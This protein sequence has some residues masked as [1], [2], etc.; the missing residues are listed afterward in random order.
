[1][2]LLLAVLLS[3]VTTFSFAQSITITSPNGGEILQGCTPFT[4]TWTE[5]G[6]SNFYDIDYSPN[7]GVTWVSVATAVNTT[8]GT[9]SWTV[10]NIASNNFMIRVIDN[11]VP[12]TN[13]QSDAVFTVEAPLL[14]NSPNGGEYTTAF[15]T[16]PI[17][18]S[19]NNTSDDYLIEYSLDNGAT[20]S[21]IVNNSTITTGLYNWSVPN[22]NSTNA[23][24]QITDVNNSCMT[25]QSDAVFTIESSIDVTQPNGGEVWQSNIRQFP[26]G[27]EQDIIINNSSQEYVYEGNTIFDHGGASG[28]YPSGSVN[29]TKTLMSAIPG[30]P[31]SLNFTQF[32]LYYYSSSQPTRNHH[33]YIYD[34]PSTNDP[35]IGDFVQNNNPGT[36]TST[37]P[38]GALT[39]RWTTSSYGGFSDLGFRADVS[40]IGLYDHP[41]Q[42]ITWDRVG[43]SNIYNIE[44]SIDNGVGWKPIISNYS[45]PGNIYR[46]H[47]P[48]DPTTQALVRV[49]DADNG[50]IIDQSDATFTIDQA[51]PHLYYPNG[52]EKLLAGLAYAI[53]WEEGLFAGSSVVLEYS[54]D[55]GATWNLIHGGTP[56]D[57]SFSWTIPDDPSTQVLVRASELGNLSVNDVSDAVCTIAPRVEITSPVGGEM[58]N[59]CETLTI[60]WCAGGTSG[61]YRLEYSED[62]GSTW[63]LIV[64]NHPLSGTNVSYDWLIAN[65]N[66]SQLVL[67]VSDAQTLGYNDV[68]P[69]LT[70]STTQYLDLTSPNGGE[71]LVFGT[72]FPIT[73]VASGPV[74]NVDLSYSTDNGATWTLLANNTSGGVYNWNVPNLSSNTAL[75][76]AVA[77]G[78]TCI[79]DQSAAVFD[80]VSE[81]TVVVPNGGENWQSVIRQFPNG[82]DQ[83]IEIDSDRIEYVYTEQRLYDHGGPTGNYSSGTVDYEVTLQPAILDHMVQLDFSVF[84]LYYYSSSQPSRNHHLYIYDGPST[85]DPLIGDYVQNNSPG[86]VTST[87][88]TGALTLRWVT[89]NYGGFSDQGFLANLTTVDPYTL[90]YETIEWDVTGTSGVYDLEYSVNNGA[91]WIPIVSS[92]TSAIGEYRWH[93]PNNPTTDALFRVIDAANGN[94]LDQSD[95]T[96]NIDKADPKLFT[97]NG[98]EQLLAGLGYSVTW[99]PGLFVVSTVQLDYSLDNGATWNVITTGT[100]NDGAHTWIVP[101]APTNQ[102]LVRVSEF[103]NTA[104]NDISDANF[105]ILSYITLTSPLGGESVNG[106]ETL[107]INW[108][109]GQTSGE[110]LLEYS[111]DAGTTWNTIDANYTA[112]GTNLSYNWV[113][114][115]LSSNQFRV[116]VSDAQFTAKTD[117]TMDMTIGSTQY[118]QLMTPNGGDN[119]VAFTLN[120]VIYATSGPVSNVNLTYSTDNGAT[121]STIVNNTSGG[122]YNW[123]IPNI[124]SNTALV[125]VMDA[126]NS[127]NYDI[128]DAPINLISEIAITQPNGGENWKSNIRQFPNGVDQDIEIDSDRIEYVYTEQRLFDHGGPTGN[129]S[130]GTVD[131][132]V[133]LQPA[134][135][136]HMVQ[137]DFSQFD[138]YFYSSSQPTRNHHLYIYDG[139]TTDDQLIG[140]YMQNNNPGTVTSTHPTGALTLRWRT[141]N[142]GGFSDLGFLA[143]L[144]TVD[145]YSHPYKEITWDITGTSGIYDLEYSVNNGASWI[146][147]ISN[148]ASASGE[149]WWHVPNNPTTEALVRVTDAANGNILDQSDATFNIDQADPKLFTPNGGEEWF[150]QAGYAITW[151]PGLF[152]ESAIRIEYTLDNGQSWNP[153]VNGTNNDGAYTWVPPIFTQSYPESKIRISEFTSGI[154]D[155]S[156]TLFTLSPA[157]QI[158]SPN[159]SPA[160]DSLRGCTETTIIYKAGGTTENYLMQY[161]ADGGLTWVD[162]E[163]SYFSDSLI[164]NYDWVIPNLYSD[165]FLI[166]VSDAGDLTKFDVTDYPYNIRQPI[167]IITPNTAGNLSVGSTYTITWESDGASN[168]YD[169]YYSTDAGASW[170]TIALNQNITNNEYDWLIP[171]DVSTQVLVRVVDNIDNCKEDVS[172]NLMSIIVGNSPIVVTSPNGGEDWVACGDSLITWTSIGTSGFFDI[173][174]S[175]NGGATWTSIV[176]NYATATNEYLWSLPAVNENQVLIRVTDANDLTRTDM[177]DGF[178][179]LIPVVPANITASGPLTFCNG[180]TVTLTSSSPTGNLWSPNGETTQSIVVSTTGTYSVQVTSGGCSAT[181]SDVD[182]VVNPIPNTPITGGDSQ[183][184]VG[185]TINLTASTIAGATYSWT[186]PS[187]FT[188]NQQNPTITNADL[189]NSGTYSVTVEVNGCSSLPNTW[190]VTVGNTAAVAGSIYTESGSQVLGVSVTATGFS[191]QTTITPNDGSYE[192]FLE[193][194]EAYSVLPSKNN[195]VV[196]SNGVTTLD[197]ILMQRHIL[198]VDPLNS[199][200]KLMAADVDFS[201]TIT[202]LDIVLAQSLIL[203][204]TTSYPNGRLWS[205][206]DSDA[207]FVDPMNPFPYVETRDYAN[208]SDLLNQDFIAM[209]L[210]DVNNS[211]NPLIAKD[212]DNVEH[213]VVLGDVSGQMNSIV[214]VPVF[215]EYDESL[216]GFQMTMDWDPKALEFVAVESG[217]VNP[218]LGGVNMVKG[219]VP[220]SWYCQDPSGIS[221]DGKVA[222]EMVFRIKNEPNKFT[223]LEVNSEI[224]N[225]EVYSSALKVRSVGSRGGKVELEGQAVVGMDVRPNPFSSELELSFE[226]A[227]AQDVQVIMIDALGKEIASKKANF[228]EGEQTIMLTDWLVPAGKLAPGMYWV[229]VET[230]NEKYIRKVV[231]L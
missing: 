111:E 130:S 30:K 183:V 24:I 187:G 94:I 98:G 137:L 198:S 83:D 120:P 226:L 70:V 45:N 1:M 109:A 42:E 101:D 93:V 81:I 197:L 219:Q 10:P 123:T 53:T 192:L 206:I 143:N 54:N 182:V 228:N 68:T 202:T 168:F 106:C 35:L 48:N 173:E 8:S 92:Y 103:G 186:G 169:L 223:D 131:Y 62:G 227:T 78:N 23:L 218:V 14:L 216:A 57:G 37:H 113:L 172:D 196:T 191:T 71:S 156:D 155:E 104:V 174:Y 40:I 151:E 201:N 12:S 126:S 44:Y 231:K 140:D 177:S 77:D 85:S 95:A 142:Y 122:S 105:D 214:K 99:E 215:F 107:T 119:L 211:W 116:R 87:H 124:S 89:S 178:F 75:I 150:S 47:V 97:P 50:N 139:P 167:T 134:I 141:S 2:R 163:S 157:I 222:F 26:G 208:V 65:V 118:V 128:S 199:P 181:S 7:G 148:Y 90:A 74:T 170:T 149:Y 21:T 28:N 135:L 207:T 159:G 13:D 162:I 210:G 195:D 146:P 190:D 127:C 230:G 16:M 117:Q 204:N 184:A 60:E 193:N 36:V 31:V 175:V 86:T 180:S 66:S 179:S 200:Y 185:A 25:D 203:Q 112:S 188:S 27:L 67:R 6:T 33:V 58:I 91:S 144:T 52:G 3:V 160:I 171:N 133:T 205:F 229:S 80:I 46:W 158:Y 61:E 41:Y 153:I 217:L 32:D 63:N 96:F 212:N 49:I 9:Y 138:L 76:R 100:N 73:Y 164:T 145:P 22:V 15:S 209:K 69:A 102:A 225:A 224:V 20:W 152:V 34:G 161:S 136:D 11:N 194:N 17:V 18:F 38:T 165:E 59:G 72:V 189:T 220:M 147:I 221:V 51:V 110:Y 82:V 56:N 213:I 132:E 19:A 108:L 84:D 176:T 121:W 88:P 29:Y 5:T 43:T 115:N 114:P 79:S 4:I 55:N 129:Y 154:F 166:K 125:R 64:D 39:V